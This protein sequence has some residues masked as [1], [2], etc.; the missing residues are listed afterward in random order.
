M[1]DQLGGHLK[2]ALS[3]DAAKLSE[4]RCIATSIKLVT[5]DCADVTGDLTLSGVTKPATLNADFK[6]AG[7]NP[8]DNLNTFGFDG[9]TTIKRS[10]FGINYGLPVQSHELR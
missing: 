3:F 2:K 6:Q 1:N 10:D 4:A 9:E 5:R 8:V 7:V